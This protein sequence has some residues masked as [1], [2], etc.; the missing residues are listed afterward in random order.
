VEATVGDRTIGAAKVREG[1]AEL[2]GTFASMRETSVPVAIQYL[3]DT[4]WWEPG[5]VLY[6]GVGVRAASAWRRAPPILLA[7]AVALWMTR[8]SWLPRMERFSRGARRRATPAD[9]AEQHA[10]KVIREAAPDHGW[11]GHVVDAHDAYP[12][13]GAIVSIVV[14]SFPGSPERP[15]AE[16]VTRD[17]GSFAIA[18][19]TISGSALLRVRAP[20][21]ATFEQPLPPPSEVSIPMVARRRRL[22]D[23]LVAWASREWGPWRGAREP[24]PDQVAAHAKSTRG[25]LGSERAAEVEAWARAVEWTAYG[26][27]NVDEHV[28]RSVSSLEP[29]RG[30]RGE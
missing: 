7:L 12:L 19:M 29:G 18:P 26:R 6:V 21:H 13:E 27:A 22:L 23:R 10:I 15:S 17:D 9:A 4:P 16:V 11:S 3:S 8:R 1:R 30:R 24:T 5:P 28:E 25:R 20:W 2:V 14:P